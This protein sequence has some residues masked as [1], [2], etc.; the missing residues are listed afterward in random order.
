MTEKEFRDYHEH[1]FD[2]FC[3]KSIKYLGADGHRKRKRQQHVTLDIDDPV[4]AYIH[5]IQTNDHY[6]FYSRTYHVQN[7]EIIVR[8]K[9]IGDALQFIVPRKRDVILLCY[10]AELKDSEVARMLN[11]S[12]TSIARRKKAGLARLREL[13]E[14]RMHA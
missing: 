12:P 8:D 11:T 3:K 13:L 1:S 10:F 2:A 6:S 9:N 5:S 4:V 14:V 7:L